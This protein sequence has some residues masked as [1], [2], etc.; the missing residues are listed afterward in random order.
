M[1]LNLSG[2]KGI[3]RIIFF[4]TVLLIMVLACEKD[5]QKA[6]FTI[7]EVKRLLAGDS[8]KT[9]IRTVRRESGTLINLQDCERN[10]SLKF[11]L[12]KDNIIKDSLLYHTGCQSEPLILG[13]W[14]VVNARDLPNTDSLLYIVNDDTTYR[15]IKNIT[16]QILTISF[17][18]TTNQTE[19]EVEE[20]YIL[21]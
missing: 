21:K 13:N 15:T 18:E 4:T 2:R 8:V 19:I 3:S 11:I 12:A 1:D 16:S 6:G 14:S 10:D 7:T 17:T 9:W 20:D 5:E